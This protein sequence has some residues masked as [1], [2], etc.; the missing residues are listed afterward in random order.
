MKRLTYDS[1]PN[2]VIRLYV[3]EQD[4]LHLFYLEGVRDTAT[5]FVY[6]YTIM[7][8]TKEQGSVWSEPEEI[9]TPEYI[10]GQSRKGGLWMDTNTG[11]IHILYPTFAGDLYD[12]T[13]YYTNS[14]IP[15]YEFTK[16]DS[17]PGKQ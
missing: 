4:K 15:D 8:R 14:T 11:I 5:G 9:K 10:F 2:K 17:L 1:L 3:D 12:D 6:D 16:I 13:L 7:Y